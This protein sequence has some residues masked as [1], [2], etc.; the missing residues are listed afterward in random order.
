MAS[1]EETVKGES[2]V[3]ASL[4]FLARDPKY[5]LIKPYTVRYDPEGKFPYTNIDNVKHDVKLC[6]LRPILD[7]APG[8]IT[9]KK[10]GF[11][12][13]TIPEQMTYEDLNNDET[14]R[15]SHIPHILTVIQ[16][17]FQAKKIHVLDYRVSFSVAPS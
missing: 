13:V 11:Q 6:D 14:L 16:S 7:E 17:R 8:D 5:K 15:G 1:T 3:I 2:Q 9:W 4:Y 10:H 12:I